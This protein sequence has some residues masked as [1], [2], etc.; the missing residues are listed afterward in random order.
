MNG[1]NANNHDGIDSSA[2][3]MKASPCRGEFIRPIAKSRLNRANEFAP[4]GK[5]TP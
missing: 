3:M 2:Q 4:T 5:R 1:T